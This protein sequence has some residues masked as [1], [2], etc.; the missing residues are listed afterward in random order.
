[1]S[2]ENVTR[3]FLIGVAGGTCSGKTTV[4]ERLVELVGSDHLALIK[5]DAYYV[6]RS[7][8][9]FDER[10]RA[11]YDHPDAFDWDLTFEQLSTLL[12][13]R[14]VDVPVYDYPNHNRSKDVLR[15]EPTRI[16]VFEGILALY[17]EKLRDLFDLRIFVDTDADVRLI[18][19]LE[20]DVRDRGRTPESIMRQYMTTVRPSHLQF[21]EPT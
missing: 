1:M 16:V 5:Q 15:I 20:R 18:R 13:G 14:G 12:T 9:P 6:D 8:Q 4:T 3:P 11:N 19:R 10:T 17:D 21:I 2:R 7:D